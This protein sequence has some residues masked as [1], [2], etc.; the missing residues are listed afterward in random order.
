MSLNCKFTFTFYV[1]NVKLTS[2]EGYFSFKDLWKAW[3]LFKA[4]GNDLV[5]VTF[6]YVF[7]SS[8][9]SIVDS[10]TEGFFI[11]VL[12]ISTSVNN[13]ND[14]STRLQFHSSQYG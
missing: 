10:L 11:I 6:I 7:L 4:N 8:T 5:V 9:L 12:I 2:D 14:P 3:E 1:F 13:P